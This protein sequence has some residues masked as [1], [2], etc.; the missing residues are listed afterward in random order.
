MKKS[1]K[2]LKTAIKVMEKERR[3]F[4]PGHHAFQS[5]IRPTEIND[6]HITGVVSGFAEADHKKYKLLD[7][8]IVGLSDLIEILEDDTVKGVPSRDKIQAL[9]DK[10]I[11]D[12][13]YGKHDG[14][15]AFSELVE[16]VLPETP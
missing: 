5:G 14:W 7:E 13:D 10:I 12:D 1:I 9:Y 2:H 15:E 8:A 16:L 3:Q 11:N 6:D 4:A